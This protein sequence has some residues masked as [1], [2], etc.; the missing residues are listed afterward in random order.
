MVWGPYQGGRILEDRIPW[1]AKSCVG[2]RILS[3][4][5]FLILEISHRVIHVSAL[6]YAI[7]RFNLTSHFLNSGLIQVKS[8][9]DLMWWSLLLLPDDEWWLMRSLR[10]LPFLNACGRI[11]EDWLVV[12][13]AGVLVFDLALEKTMGLVSVLLSSLIMISTVQCSSESLLIWV[14]LGL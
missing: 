2:P 8:P 3:E 10:A 7:K 5:S 14:I 9:S 11:I 13:C 12:V 6:S 1:L 4:V